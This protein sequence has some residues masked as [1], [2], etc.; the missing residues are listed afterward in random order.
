MG[1]WDPNPD[2]SVDDGSIWWMTEDDSVPYSPEADAKIPVGTIIPGVLH[3]GKYSGDRNDV[4]GAAHWQ[5]GYW[6]LIAS[7]NLTTGSK[8][9]QDFIPGRILYIWVAVFDHTQT[10]HTRHPRPV[11]LVVQE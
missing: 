1:H 10:R 7:R 11:R 9:D 3:L 8:Y 4:S 2:A 6:T 5:D